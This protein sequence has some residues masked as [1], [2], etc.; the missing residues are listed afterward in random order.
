LAIRLERIYKVLGLE[1]HSISINIFGRK[2]PMRVESSEEKKAVEEAA[3]MINE[4]ISSFKEVYTTQ[5]D[6][7]VALMCCLNIATEHI[8]TLHRTQDSQEKTTR[9][10]DNME[11]RLAHMLK[12]R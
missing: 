7:N 9:E 4:Q 2:F 11:H 8:K 3:R 1:Q 6:L 12:D 5:D 10:L